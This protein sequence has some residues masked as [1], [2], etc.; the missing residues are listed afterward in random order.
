VNIIKYAIYDE[1]LPNFIK[2][3]H[4]RKGEQKKQGG[5]T[6]SRQ[7]SKCVIRFGGFVRTLEDH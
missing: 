7:A 2:R 6:K 3:R 5:R 1:T 4:L